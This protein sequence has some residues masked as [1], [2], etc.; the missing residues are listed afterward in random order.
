[1]YNKL[2]IYVSAKI[3]IKTPTIKPKSLKKYEDM[4]GMKILFTS[5]NCVYTK[6]GIY[7]L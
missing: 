2:A 1:M 5:S 3:N 7:A 6:T 4:P